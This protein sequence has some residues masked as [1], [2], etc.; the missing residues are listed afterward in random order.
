[1]AQAGFSLYQIGK[2][3]YREEEEDEDEDEDEKEKVPNEEKQ[4]EVETS[5]L[6]KLVKQAEDIYETVKKN[7]I[8]SKVEQQ[9]G[10]TKKEKGTNF[11]L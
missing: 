4:N 11:Q 7:G 10:L 2:A 8:Q 9:I 5:E 6:E 1:M 3:A